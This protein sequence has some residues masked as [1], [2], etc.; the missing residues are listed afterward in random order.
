MELK[1]QYDSTINYFQSYSSHAISIKDI[2]YQ[3]SLIVT[4]RKI[5][6]DWGPTNIDFVSGDDIEKIVNLNPEVIL[7]GTGK[8]LR[9]PKPEFYA[10][11]AGKNVG[12]EF[13]DTLAAC[14]TYNVLATESREVATGLILE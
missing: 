12:I 6:A 10:E 7:I 4:P 2:E 13:M 1:L 11:I 3:S 8:R 9:F 14:R 5:I